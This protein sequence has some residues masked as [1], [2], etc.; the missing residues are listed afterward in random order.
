VLLRA[1]LLAWLL[2]HLSVPMTTLSVGCLTTAPPT[3]SAPKLLR[4]AQPWRV[5]YASLH[6]DLA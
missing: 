2:T 3:M 5:G 4:S 1:H 6:A